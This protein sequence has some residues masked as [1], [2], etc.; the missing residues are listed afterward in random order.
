MFQNIK[1]AKCLAEDLPEISVKYNVTAVPKFVLFRNGD[2]VDA[3]DGAD[4]IQLNKKIQA[5]VLYYYLILIINNIA[6]NISFIIIC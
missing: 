4:P 3:L 6:F 1:I 5:L 2:E